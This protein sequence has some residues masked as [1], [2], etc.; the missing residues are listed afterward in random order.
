MLH[1]NQ[2]MER[3]PLCQVRRFITENSANREIMLVHFR[4]I[5]YPPTFQMKAF[6]FDLINMYNMVPELSNRIYQQTAG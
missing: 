5:Q 4:N 2:L 3:N 1:T 6:C